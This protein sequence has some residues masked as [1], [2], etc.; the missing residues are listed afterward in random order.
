MSDSLSSILS[1]LLH[2]GRIL[3][4]AGLCI[5]TDGNF[6]ARLNG[7]NILITRSGIEKR[8]LSG[9]SFVEVNLSDE[10]TASASSEWLLHQ[11]MYSRPDVACVLHVHAPFLTTFSVAHK[12]PPTN[13]LAEAFDAVGEITLVP[14][15]KPGTR[16]LSQ[17]VLDA[18]PRAM[19]YLLANHGAVSV[20]S[21][22]RDA[23]H[24]IE[25]AEFVARVA[26]QCAALGGGIPLTTQQ[27]TGAVE[28]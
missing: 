11:A 18:N 15:C 23:L 4:E 28:C 20:G 17:R 13:L 3:E 8:D 27:L 22:V 14:F 6:S 12:V 24:R 5:A 2:A 25:R 19:V 7:E 10:M 26:W 16:E 21:S 9:A 1:E